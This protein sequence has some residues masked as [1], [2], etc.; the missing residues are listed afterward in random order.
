MLVVPRAEDTADDCLEIFDEP[1]AVPLGALVG[2]VDE[3]DAIIV[4]S[5]L[6]VTKKKKKA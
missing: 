5:S 6:S 1:V 2:P 4:R 3:T